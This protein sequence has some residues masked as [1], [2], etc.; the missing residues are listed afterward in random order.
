MVT[1]RLAVESWFLQECR[2]SRDLHGL[3]EDDSSETDAVT[4]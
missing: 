3:S 2:D 4:G 1:E